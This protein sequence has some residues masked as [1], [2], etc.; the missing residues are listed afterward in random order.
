MSTK[1]YFGSLLFKCAFNLFVLSIPTTSSIPIST[2]NGTTEKRNMQKECRHTSCVIKAFVQKFI[3]KRILRLQFKYEDDLSFVF[4]DSV[5]LDDVIMV[6]LSEY[7]HLS[8]DILQQHTASWS[9]YTSFTDELGRVVDACSP[10][11]APPHHSELTAK[12][13]RHINHSAYESALRMSILWK[14]KWQY[15]SIIIL[16]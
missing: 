16:I 15:D 11:C 5:E 9:P 6:N 7:V 13:D 2:Y 3:F 10:T 12:V 8:A 14:H 4:I 1:I